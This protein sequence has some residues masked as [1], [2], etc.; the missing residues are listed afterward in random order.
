VRLGF[1]VSL[2]MPHLPKPSKTLGFAIASSAMLLL[3]LMFQWNIIDVLTLFI[4]LPLLGLVWLVVVFGVIWSVIYAYRHRRE[5]LPAYRPTFVYGGAIVIALFVPFTQLW[6]YANFHINKAA[7]EQVIAK[8]R[9]GDFKPNVSH[10][11]SLIALPNG[12]GVSKGGDEIIVQGDRNNP[13]VFF[14]TFRGILDN[15]SGFLWV[16]D[17]ETPQEFQDAGEAGTE[18]EPFGGN[19]YFIGHR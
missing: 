4:G 18:I 15:Y 7:R 3:A 10:N 19:W 1:G 2:H 9:S 12:Y 8:V 6:L 13:F 16:P 14:F 11:A 17:G 5:G